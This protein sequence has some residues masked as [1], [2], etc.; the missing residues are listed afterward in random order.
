MSTV[1]EF[2]IC[3]GLLLAAIVKTLLRFRWR[4]LTTPKGRYR[5]GPSR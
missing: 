1:M 4:R 3:R 2:G 5:G